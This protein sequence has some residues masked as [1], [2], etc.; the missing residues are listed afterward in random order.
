MSTS[1]GTKAIIAALIANLGI[2]VMKFVAFLFSGSSSM[3][4][5]SIHSLADSG[6]QVL[7]LVGGKRSKRAPTP[8]HPFGYGRERFVYAF[9][10]SIIL[11]SLGGLFSLYEGIHK[12]Q[13]PE[14][15][16]VPWLP[17]AVLIGA[18]IL[19]SYSFRTAIKEANLVR[20]GL[21]WVEFIRRA[22]APELPVILLEDFAALIGLVLALAGVSVAIITGDGVWDGVGTI[23]IGVLLVLVACVLAVETKSLLLGEGALSADVRRITA[24]AEDGDSIEKVIHMQTLYLGPDELLVAMKVAVHPTDDATEVTLAIDEVEQRVRAAVPIVTAMYVE[25]DILRTPVTEGGAR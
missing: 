9:L 6:N 16:T 20:H 21:G 4:G 2:A 3:L 15:L 1:G 12:V 18:I 7:L 23:C 8:E 13:N 22:K 17:I 11:F 14:P 24:A 19:E 5:E 10:V 25:P